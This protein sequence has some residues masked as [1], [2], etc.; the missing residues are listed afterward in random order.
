VQVVAA[1]RLEVTGATAERVGTLAAERSIPV[2]ECVTAA[3]DLE[4]V[5]FQLTAAS[6]PA[7]VSR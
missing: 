6:T 3:A 2:F 5:F 7:E 1:D 4:D